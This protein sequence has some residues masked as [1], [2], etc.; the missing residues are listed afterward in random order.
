M[1]PVNPTAPV[2]THSGAGELAR[3]IANLFGALRAESLRGEVFNLFAHPSYFPQLMSP[4]PCVI[5]GGRGTGKTTVLRSLSYEGQASLAESSDSPPWESIGLYWRIDTSVVSAFGGSDREESVWRDLFSHYV[6]VTMLQLAAKYLDWATH[7]D[8]LDVVSPTTLRRAAKSIGLPKTPASVVELLEGLDDLMLDLEDCLNDTSVNVKTSLLGKPLEYLLTDLSSAGKLEGRYVTFLVDEYENLDASQ[9]R[10]VNTLIK[11]SGDHGYTFKVGVREM[12]QRDR[13]TLNADEYLVAPADYTYIDIAERL[14]ENDFAAFA[15]SVC[16]SRLRR[17][18]A[19]HET[20][21]TI[22]ELLPGL[23]EESEIAK[24]GGEYTR[25]HIR[26][27]LEIQGA[28][29]EQLAKFDSMSL[30][31][32]NMVGYWAESKKAPELDV[33]LEATSET[34]TWASRLNNY[35][36]TMLFTIRR[37]RSGT[38]KY[39]CGWPTLVRLAHG[40]IRYLLQ[41]V[42]DSLQTHVLG[43]SD[44]TRPV[45]PEIQ[46]ASAIK[47]GARAVEQLQGV[48]AEG[49]EV[50]RLVLGLGRIFEV[51]ASLP[52]GHAPEVSQFR[53]VGTITPA[54]SLL[55]TSVMHLALLRMPT[56]KRGSVGDTKQFSYQLHPIFA[57]YF[58]YS[59]R[60]K[61][62][63]DLTG[64]DLVE[65]VNNHKKAIPS[66]L[67]RTTR[68]VEEA[69]LPDQLSLFQDYYD[70]AD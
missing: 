37:G 49:R 10:I 50:T 58:G 7:R 44:L 34:S 21:S 13:S 17:L 60:S 51:M 18:S 41:L 31:S 69:P 29:P 9:Q 5:V 42:H 54:E 62:R 40:N 38:R 16:N 26:S 70:A 24:L 46:T 52:H 22:E 64:K 30:L 11:H 56:D 35:Q 12:G 55:S 47:V 39:Y 6:N 28:T 53:V 63:M 57:P 23:S 33:L 59:S 15:Q 19:T 8:L 1:A 14:I 61:R 43:Y 32:A 66:I 36:H 25:K 48:H 65:L 45:S 68:S 3:E 67:N 20:I 2:N 4:L 27:Q